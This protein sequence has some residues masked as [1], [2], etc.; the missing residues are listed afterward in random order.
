MKRL[1]LFKFLNQGLF[2]IILLFL[3]SLLSGCSNSPG[4]DT[5][6]RARDQ[7]RIGTTMGIKRVNPLTDYYYNILALIMTHDSLVRFDPEV[8]VV[9]QLAERWRCSEGGRV[10]RFWLVPGA[11][12]HDGYPVTADD[13]KFTFEYL[14]Q[15]DVNSSWI[16]D[17]IEDIEING[18][19]LTFRLKK[20]Y[21]RFLINA[22]FIVRILPKHIWQGI[23]D[24]RK[25]VGKE[26]TIGCGPYVFK[27]FDRRIGTIRFDL[28]KDYYGKVPSVSRV[29]FYLYKNMDVLTMAF[30]KNKID[31]YYKYAAG[32]PFQ[33]IGRLRKSNDLGFLE[34]LSMGVQAALGFNISHKP[35]DQK[36]I[37]EAIALAINY[38]RINQCIFG[39]NGQIPSRGFVPPVFPFWKETVKLTYDPEQSRKLLLSEGLEDRDG[40]GVREFPNGKKWTISLLARADL[41]GEDQLIK[42]LVNDLRAVGLRT[43]V[44]SVDLSTWIALLQDDRYDMVLFRTTPWGMMMHAGYASGYFDSRRKGGGAIGNLTDPD[45][46]QL[47]DR[48][49]TTTDLSS[50]KELYHRL[51][52]YYAMHLPAVAL[53][54]GKNI[55]PFRKD[56]QGFRV[57]QLEGGLANRFS[58][59]F[60]KYVELSTSGESR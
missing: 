18:R 8:R 29:S 5:S 3:G 28:N 4:D 7:L 10:W 17:L 6:L 60:L 41:W 42:L 51:Q 26:A 11:R 14:A 54:W 16:A 13:I 45:F 24:P 1:L 56:W 30:L 2:F 12:W 38:E 32:Y 49:L 31:T 58:W 52:N 39:G 23:G 47:C 9:P 15:K 40:D 25:F 37:R 34:A 55:Y 48:I 53:C 35:L 27:T 44:R 22:G 57:H 50:L 21:S 19:E 43:V 36:K 33:Y 59:R 20:P 46:L